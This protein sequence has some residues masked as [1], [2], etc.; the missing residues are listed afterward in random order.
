MNIREPKVIHDFQD[1]IK[2]SEVNTSAK[3]YK[4]AKGFY[5]NTAAL[6]DDTL[7][8][9]VYHYTQGSDKRAG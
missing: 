1:V 4:D 5:R 9:E 7:M 2:G 8:Y 6:A 3:L